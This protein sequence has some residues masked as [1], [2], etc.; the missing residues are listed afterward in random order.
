[1]APVRARFRQ[2]APRNSNGDTFEF[3]ASGF[4]AELELLD[5]TVAGTHPHRD[6]VRTGVGETARVRPTSYRRREAQTRLPRAGFS[7]CVVSVCGRGQFRR[8]VM[9]EEV[10]GNDGDRYI[11][12][13][14]FTR[15]ST[16]ER[17][18]L[19]ASLTLESQ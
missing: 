12:L 16:A 11:A 13:R 15:D 9:A 17:R 3:F 14:R 1:M 4:A 19:I 7:V 18:Q 6:R 8:L 2:V 5:A 10:D